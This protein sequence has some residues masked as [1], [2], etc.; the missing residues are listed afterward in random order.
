MIEQYFRALT[1]I[2]STAW[3]N[4]PRSTTSDDEQLLYLQFQ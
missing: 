1:N 4:T 3:F 2:K